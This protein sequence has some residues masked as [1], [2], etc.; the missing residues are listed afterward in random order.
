MTWLFQLF[1]FKLMVAV[2]IVLYHTESIENFLQNHLP[3][4]R[5][6][7]RNGDENVA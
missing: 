1:V 6:N 7:A 3:R 4:R 5:L 2:A